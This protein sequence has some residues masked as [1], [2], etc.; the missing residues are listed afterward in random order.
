MQIPTYVASAGQCCRPYSKSITPYIHWEA[1]LRPSQNLTPV[2][3]QPE[4]EEKG[5]VLVSHADH[6]LP[7]VTAE[8]MD[9]F[10]ANMEKGY[11]LWAPGSHKY[12]QWIREP[13]EYGFLGSSHSAGENLEEYK[14]MMESVIPKLTYRFD[15]S[16]FMFTECLAH[17]IVEGGVS[18]PEAPQDNYNVHMWE[19]T[20]EGLLHRTA[21]IMKKGS[22]IYQAVPWDLFTGEPNVP[23]HPEFEAYRWSVFLPKLYDLWKDHPD[24]TQN[25]KCD[26]SVKQVGPMKWE[27]CFE[28]GPVPIG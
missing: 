5:W 9:W 22:G 18:D 2:R 12:F 26:L 27:Y 19:D 7:G 3:L 8:M 24:P 6:I 13:W 16:H 17:A 21:M 4:W 28:N 11:L 10:W 15:M 20:P 1:P 14:P 23:E 25:V